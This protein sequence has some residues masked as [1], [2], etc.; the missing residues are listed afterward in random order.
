MKS[1]YHYR[2]YRE[3]LNDFYLE[4]KQAEGYSLRKFADKIGFGSHTF[5]KQVLEGKRNLGAE[6][7]EKIAIAFEFSQEETA[8]LQALVSFC[9]ADEADVKA[10]YYHAMLQHIPQAEPRMI[11]DD[12]FMLLDTWY[13]TAILELCAHHAF[14][15]SAKWMSERLRPQ[16][17]EQEV[18]QSFE[19]LSRLKLV[20]KDERGVLRPTEENITTGQEII[21]LAA[22]AYHKNL[23][24]LAE[25][26]ISQTPPHWRDLSVTSVLAN[27]EDFLFIKEEVQNFRRRILAYL[28]ERQKLGLESGMATGQQLYAMNMQLFPM[29]EVDWKESKN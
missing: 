10:R 20:A 1:V 8:F 21:H 17:S 14:D 24:R 3:W 6:S 29:T 2:D 7:V 23:L 19:L 11:Q 22:I 13:H 26:S 12:Q 16:V 5:V 25:N 27:R 9:H 4:K 15:G 18:E 28:A